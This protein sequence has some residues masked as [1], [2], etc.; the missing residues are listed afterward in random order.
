[1]GRKRERD[2]KV[3]REHATRSAAPADQCNHSS[4]TSSSSRSNAHAVTYFRR[5]GEARRPRCQDQVPC[6]RSAPWCGKSCLSIPTCPQQGCLRRDRTAP[7]ASHVTS[8][9]EEFCRRFLGCARGCHCEVDQQ[10]LVRHFP[11]QCGHRAP[12]RRQPDPRLS[13]LCILPVTRGVTRR[14]RHQPDG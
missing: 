1:M 10:S 3:E 14:V 7:Q 12:N 11:Q 6:S 8:C 2:Q 13:S 5:A 9:H 4:S